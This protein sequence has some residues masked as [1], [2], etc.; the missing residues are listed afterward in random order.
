MPGGGVIAISPRLVGGVFNPIPKPAPGTGGT[1]QY[2][3]DP[4]GIAAWLKTIAEVN[5]VLNIKVTNGSSL[6]TQPTIDLYKGAD[7]NNLTKLDSA[8]GVAGVAELNYSNAEIVAGSP[9]WIALNGVDLG[10][11]WEVWQAAVPTLGLPIFTI[12]RNDTRIAK[13]LADAAIAGVSILHRI[14]GQNF[15]WAPYNGAYVR[16]P[17]IYQIEAIAV[18]NGYHP[19]AIATSAIV[20][21][22]GVRGVDPSVPND[23]VV[24]EFT[25]LNTSSFYALAK[26][27]SQFANPSI[28]LFKID[29]SS[30]SGTKGRVEGALGEAALLLKDKGV[31][32]IGQKYRIIFTGLHKGYS[33]YAWNLHTTFGGIAQP[34]FSQSAGKIVTIE[35]GS[36]TIPTIVWRVKDS[37]QPWNVY[38]T[39]FAAVQGQTIEAKAFAPGTTQSVIK[40]YVVT[41]V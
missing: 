5:T 27:E 39:P 23:P 11:G 26:N 38:Q 29:D 16:A 25:A 14:K 13:A 10:T 30:P 41:A 18:K 1:E 2:W 34:A 20:A 19:S 7:I 6:G 40:E 15:P 37:G 28:M 35:R 24:I 9:Y 32:E 4:N 12:T 8:V 3:V 33:W 21:Q 17:G 36:Q 22:V 31:I